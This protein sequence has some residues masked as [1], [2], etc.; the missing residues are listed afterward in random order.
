[1]YGTA[2]KMLNT[3]FQIYSLTVAKLPLDDLNPS[4]CNFRSYGTRANALFNHSRWCKRATVPKFSLHLHPLSD[5]TDDKFNTYLQFACYA[6]Y[7]HNQYSFITRL[8][9]WSRG[10]I[11]I[12]GL[13]CE[14]VAPPGIK[15]WLLFSVRDMSW[16]LRNPCFT[17]FTVV[18]FL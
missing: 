15:T 11:D 18:S 7:H 1:M 10:Q 3:L 5:R 13:F 8:N 14:F 16:G 17:K 2:Y 6:F 9:I 12:Y 4:R